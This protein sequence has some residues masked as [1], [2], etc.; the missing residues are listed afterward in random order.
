MNLYSPLF[1]FLKF[2]YLLICVHVCVYVLVETIFFFLVLSSQ[3][4]VR[5]KGCAREG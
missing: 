2:Y 3:L 4:L 1:L 5:R